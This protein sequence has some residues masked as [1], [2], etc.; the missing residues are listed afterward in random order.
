MKD[1]LIDVRFT[2]NLKIEQ[3]EDFLSRIGKYSRNIKVYQTKTTHTKNKNKRLSFVLNNIK[4]DKEYTLGDLKNK[5]FHL[6]YPRGKSQLQ[7]DLI[8]LSIQN[9]IKYINK[10]GCRT[11]I[12]LISP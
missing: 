2:V 1:S 4:P 3:L 9:K 6:G 10:R 5:L 7:Q 8:V 12:S 11:R